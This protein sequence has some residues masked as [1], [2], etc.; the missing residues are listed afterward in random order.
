MS[1]VLHIVCWFSVGRFIWLRDRT[2]G[3]SCNLCLT[4]FGFSLVFRGRGVPC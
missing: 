4:W 3:S 2:S 1:F